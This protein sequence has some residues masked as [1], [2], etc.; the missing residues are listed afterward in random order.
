MEDTNKDTIHNREL[1]ETL[2]RI[3]SRMKSELAAERSKNQELQ[4]DLDRSTTS[5]TN[6]IADS[7]IDLD[8]LRRAGM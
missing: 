8:A 3:I 1:I 5:F 2:L 6:L 7:Q 4:R